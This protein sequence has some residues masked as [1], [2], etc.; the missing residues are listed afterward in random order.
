MWLTSTHTWY[1]QA[2][3]RVASK[4]D[5][6]PAMLH[7]TPHQLPDTNI[8]SITIES[9]YLGVLT[10]WAKN[11]LKKPRHTLLDQPFRVATKSHTEKEQRIRNFKHTRE[12]DDNNN[13]DPFE[14][15][16]LQNC[17]R[18]GFSCTFLPSM[19]RTRTNRNTN[20]TEQSEKPFENTNQIEFTEAN[21]KSLPQHHLQL[22]STRHN[23]D[24]LNKLIRFVVSFGDHVT[25]G[26]LVAAT[27]RNKSHDKH[28]PTMTKTHQTTKRQ[29]TH[30]D[31]QA[32]K[33]QTIL[34]T[35]AWPMFHNTATKAMKM[36]RKHASSNAESK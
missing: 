17:T 5:T 26:E 7:A 15:K 36:Q 35:N 9:T 1:K 33:S 6:L 4:L 24:V 25:V 8:F 28:H 11:A 29:N 12:N 13:N 16:N 2:F 10:P 27:P 14:K 32:A 21:N 22:I 31:A 20:V 3:Y 30:A 18:C 23:T 34:Y 19:Y